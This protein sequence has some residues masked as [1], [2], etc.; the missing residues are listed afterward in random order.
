MRKAVPRDTA[1]IL[2]S[3]ALRQAQRPQAIGTASQLSALPEGIESTERRFENAGAGGMAEAIRMKV[4]SPRE[5]RRRERAKRLLEGEPSS[6]K[7]IAQ[8]FTLEVAREATRKAKANNHTSPEVSVN[9]IADPKGIV[10]D[11]NEACLVLDLSPKASAALSRRC[12]QHV[13][14]EKGSVTSGNLASEIDQV[15][16]SLPSHLADY[17]DAI[18][19]VGNFA[20][21]PSKSTS[22]GEIVDV[23]SGEAEWCLDVLEELFDFYYVQ[24]KRSADKRKA[25]DAKL[26]SMGKRPMK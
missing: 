4:E 18:R 26:A 10:E 14:R 24:P 22:T 20:A 13:L 25:L 2:A 15:L 9:S 8:T 21:H 12:L 3:D 1:A 23:E 5:K 7:K 6:H 16:P 19:N 11:Y 17:L